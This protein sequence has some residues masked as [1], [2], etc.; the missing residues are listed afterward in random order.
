VTA[1]HFVEPGNTPTAN[2][3]QARTDE[4]KNHATC[5]AGFV[6]LSATSFLYRRSMRISVNSQRRK[7]GQ[8]HGDILSTLWRAISHPFVATHYHGLPGFNLADA[9]PALHLKATGQHYGKLVKVRRLP[10]L[11][12]A[13]WTHHPRNAYCVDFGADQANEFLDCL[14]RFPLGFDSYRCFND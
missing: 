11:A 4:R 8:T 10:R 14:R 5:R 2:H 3:E 13:R 6:F 1:Q 9:I 7:G 12:P